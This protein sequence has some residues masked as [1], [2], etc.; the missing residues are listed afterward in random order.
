VASLDFTAALR[1]LAERGVD[2]VVVGGVGA[3]LQSAPATTFDLG[4]V[5]STEPANVARLLAALEELD[6]YYR[7]QPERRL[8]PDATHLTSPGHQL[9]MTRY[10]PLDVLGSIGKGRHYADLLPHAIE[11]EVAEGVR[12]RVLDLETLIA[13]KE[14]TGGEKDLAHCRSCAARL[15]NR[16]GGNSVGRRKRLPHLCVTME[17]SDGLRRHSHP[18]DRRH[19]R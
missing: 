10:G 3:A 15:R 14:E 12:V 18:G 9:L 19:V 11:M 7:L 13:T 6:A 17:G 5:Y 1:V 4:V 16:G 8:R 2:F